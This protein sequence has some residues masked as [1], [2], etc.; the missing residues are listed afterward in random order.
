MSEDKS[1]VTTTSIADGL[2]TDVTCASV[3]IRDEMSGCP[4]SRV[5]VWFTA[6]HRQGDR[7][8]GGGGGYG[9]GHSSG[10][11]SIDSLSAQ[12]GGQKY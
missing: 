8:G 1:C 5:I 3:P 6:S 2:R 11:K 10:L 4:V 12:P 7:G 9:G